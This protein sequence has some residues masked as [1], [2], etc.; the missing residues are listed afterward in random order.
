MCFFVVYFSFFNAEKNGAIWLYH[1]TRKKKKQKNYIYS[2][3]FVKYLTRTYKM[4][5]SF[6]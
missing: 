5:S 2:Y 1:K 4:G 3:M 6:N